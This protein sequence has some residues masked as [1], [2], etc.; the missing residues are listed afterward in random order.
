MKELVPHTN[1]KHFTIQEGSNYKVVMTYDRVEVISF[2][3]FQTLTNAIF[4]TDAQFTTVNDVIV[5]VKDI[6]LIEPTT[7][8][9]PTQI[10]H[11]KERE[12]MKLDLEIKLEKIEKVKRARETEYLNQ[13]LGTNWKPSQVYLN[14]ALMREARDYF[15]KQEP[16]LWE[17]LEKLVDMIDKV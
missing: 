4:R 10:A 17:E 2:E 6:R 9:T 7:E 15:K 1:A 14:A 16:K 3:H 5:Q 12:Q 8:P 13:K 11:R